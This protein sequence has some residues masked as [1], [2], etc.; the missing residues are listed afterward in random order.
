AWAPGVSMPQAPSLPTAPMYWSTSCP[1]WLKSTGPTFAVWPS[2]DG[3][4]LGAWLVGG[5]EVCLVVVPPPGGCAVPPLPEPPELTTIN[6]TATITTTAA[7]IEPI[8]MPLRLPAAEDGAPAPF[9]GRAGGMNAAVGARGE[10]CGG[11][12]GAPWGLALVRCHGGRSAGA[13]GS[14]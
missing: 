8:R 11:T 9:A 3:G 12:A 13:T 7:A 6:T 2:A 1:A 14:G 10:R 5:A 4:A